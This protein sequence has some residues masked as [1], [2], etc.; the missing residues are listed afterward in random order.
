MIVRRIHN[1]T[2]RPPKVEAG[3]M[4]MMHSLGARVFFDKKGKFHI[5]DKTSNQDDQ[6]QQGQ[7]GGQTSQSG[8]GGG[9]KSPLKNAPP[10]KPQSCHIQFDGKGKMKTTCFQQDSRQQGQ[11]PADPNSQESP[12]PFSIHEVDGKGSTHT[13]TTYQKG[14]GGQQG[15]GQS[16][17]QAQ[18]DTSQGDPGSEAKQSQAK[19]FTQ[20]KMDRNKKSL[21]VDTYHDNSDNQHHNMTMDNQGKKLTVQSFK[22]GG[23]K[24][25]MMEMDVQA[26]TLKTAT[27]G[28][29]EKASHTLSKEGKITAKAESSHDTDAPQINHNGK[30]NCQGDITC[31]GNIRCSGNISAASFSGLNAPTGGGGGGGGGSGGGGFRSDVNIVTG[32]FI[33]STTASTTTVQVVGATTSSKFLGAPTPLTAAAANTAKENPPPFYQM[34]DGNF[35]VT[36][37]NNGVGDRKFSYAIII[38]PVVTS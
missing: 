33:L 20:I 6:N 1:D 5:Y 29:G 31:N 22:E 9:Q 7:Q 30:T 24:A 32:T 19:K 23:D 3:E 18:P 34:G 4:L 2:D 26:G 27:Y 17:G 13:I 37:E 16:G 10:L 21:T 8:S 14:Q 36:H 35:I 25:H 28:S 11:D 15:G 12:D 38:K